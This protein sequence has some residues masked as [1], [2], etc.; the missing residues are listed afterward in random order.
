VI[1]VAILFFLAALAIFGDAILRV[2]PLAPQPNDILLSPSGSHPFGTDAFGRDVLA[3]VVDATHRDLLVPALIVGF[4]APLG[5][6]FGVIAGYFGGTLGQVIMRLTDVVLSFPGF[7]LA[8]V[9]V[10]VLG[11]GIGVVVGALA[12]ANTPYFV[13][14]TRSRVLSERN[15]EY[16]E[17]AVSA[18]NPGWRVALLHVLPN[19]AAPSLAQATLAFGWAILDTAGLAYLGVGIVPPTPEWGVMIGDGVKDVPQGVWWTTSFPGLFIL[20]T[21]LAAN[22]IGVYLRERQE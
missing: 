14:I 16:V 6:F 7:L 18:G 10:A 19:S 5:T 8:L 21:A 1:G 15:L 11:N 12:I 4:A 22:L 2:D 17:A 3:R 20:L 13:R 9:I